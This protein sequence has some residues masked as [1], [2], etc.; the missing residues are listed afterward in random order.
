MEKEE[1]RKSNDKLKYEISRTKWNYA[2][3]LNK[4]ESGFEI[5]WENSSIIRMCIND[6]EKSSM[7]PENVD[8]WKIRQLKMSQAQVSSKAQI[9]HITQTINYPNIKILLWFI[10]RSMLY[11]KFL[12]AI[13]ILFNFNVV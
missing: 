6:D 4:S 11:D 2:V 10:F 13:K 5:L 3:K 8:N 9:S 12:D 7:N 1:H